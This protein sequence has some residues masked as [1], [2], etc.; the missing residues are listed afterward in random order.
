MNKNNILCY[1]SLFNEFDNEDWVLAGMDFICVN[2]GIRI[3]RNHCR[4]TLTII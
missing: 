1:I 4:F 3:K 2:Y